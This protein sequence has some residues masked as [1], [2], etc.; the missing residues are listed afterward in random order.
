M[1]ANRFTA[2]IDACV[3]AGALKRNIL[4]SLA[5][6]QFFRPRWSPRI[7]DET[8]RAI[9]E[10]LLKRGDA[11]AL[12]TAD[13]QVGAIRTAFADASED[14]FDHLIASLPSLP[15]PK[16]GHVIAAA[17]SSGAAIIVTDNLRDFPPNVLD[18]FG[19]EAKDADAF[20]ADTIDLDIG[21][22]VQAIQTMRRRFNRPSLTPEEL[23]LKFETQGLLESSDMLRPHLPSL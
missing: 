4:L 17:I 8:E 21:R 12:V 10:M 18:K 2:L 9:A 19:I 15:D 5:E 14:G 13:R 23:L 3:L 11:D 7:L 1:F 16:D 22:A 6:A 20:I